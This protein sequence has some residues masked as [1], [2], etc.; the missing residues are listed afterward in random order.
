MAKYGGAM[1]LF[2]PL[3]TSF[4]SYNWD[5][6]TAFTITP[7]TETGKFYDD[8]NKEEWKPFTAYDTTAEVRR[9]QY[10]Y[11][12]A[13]EDNTDDPFFNYIGFDPT[14]SALYGNP[15]WDF[16]V[17]KNSWIRGRCLHDFDCINYVSPGFTQRKDPFTIT[18]YPKQM[19][20]NSEILKALDSTQM[21][22][23]LIL[24]GV[25]GN[26]T[27]TFYDDSGNTVGE[28]LDLV[29]PE[30]GCMI[31]TY[32]GERRICTD[33][34]S[35]VHPEIP[36]L[37]KDT[38]YIPLPYLS[39]GTTDKI[40]IDFKNKD[41]NNVLMFTQIGVKTIIIAQGFRL[42]YTVGTELSVGAVD[43]SRLSFDDWGKMSLIRGKQAK[44]LK[45]TVVLHREFVEKKEFILRLLEASRAT[46]TIFHAENTL[47]ENTFLSSLCYLHG[48]IKS[49]TLEESGYKNNKLSLQIDG[50]PVD[51]NP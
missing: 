16:N 4:D 8:T 29:H 14:T 43:Y 22:P 3:P 26:I 32:P 51:Y 2:R 12:S 46:P 17:G 6:S 15:G 50:M 42:G 25:Q 47:E 9:G 33:I 24:H 19:G 20:K 18:L 45:A 35:T 40:T 34:F 13:K 31:T 48:I 49:V 44:T 11:Y 23:F 5:V 28:P 39:T 38:L 36:S 21:M 37:L 1:F 27:L 10:I 41:I 7:A 30:Q